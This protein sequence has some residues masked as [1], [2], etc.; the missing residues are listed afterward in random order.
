MIRHRPHVPSARLE[1]CTNPRRTVA[2]ASR[3]FHRLVHRAGRALAQA[4]AISSSRG[5]LNAKKPWQPGLG[6]RMLLC[7]SRLVDHALQERSFQRCC[8]VRSTTCHH[9][10]RRKGQR[11]RTP[12]TQSRRGP[13]AQVDVVGQR[14]YLRRSRFAGSLSPNTL[15]HARPRIARRSQ[16]QQ[17][18]TAKSGFSGR[19][20][21]GTP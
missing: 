5:S 2:S 19:Q 12:T 6:T 3:L 10:S 18:V 14:D 7:A 4:R 15:R 13:I 9:R 17:V 11:R 8:R 20:P 1:T 21:A 16:P